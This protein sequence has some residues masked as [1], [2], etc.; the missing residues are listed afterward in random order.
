MP[1]TDPAAAARPALVVKI[2]NA[3][4]SYSGRPQQGINQADVIYEEMVEGSVTRFAA[5][6]H[7]QQAAERVIPV[8]S[9]RSTDIALMAPLRR[10]LFAWSGANEAFARLI[11]SAPLVDV[12]YD[13]Q[14]GIYRRE[15]SRRAPVNLWTTTEELWAR[16]PQG[17]QPPPAMFTYR[18]ANQDP[19]GS[20]ASYARVNY[21][22]GA[23]SAPVELRWDGGKRVWLRFQNGTPHVDEKGVQVGARNVIIQT[24]PYHD[25]GLVDVARNPV[26]E[27]DLV[28]SGEA[29]VLTN[30]R[31][32]RAR[33]SKTAAEAVTA[34]VDE[35]GKPV[36]LT[37]GQTWVL[38]PFAG[39]SLVTV[40]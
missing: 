14:P 38:L 5:I 29:I 37:P 7:S 25:T 35:A 19:G 39:R 18:V 2:D 6:F 36:L 33:W 15:R 11:R 16:T 22:T 30:G 13:A 27:A 32:I 26:Y 21:G 1:V 34:Y 9:A 20:P 10:P 17:A 28:G 40:E 4:G 12:G 8:R 24:T 31:A 3:D 23:G